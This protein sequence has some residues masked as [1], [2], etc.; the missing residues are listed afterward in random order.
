MKLRRRR[1]RTREEY[2]RGLP[3]HHEP[4][5][6]LAGAPP[7][8]SALSFRIVLAGIALLLSVAGSVAFAIADAPWVSVV[9]G[10]V[11]VCSAINLGWVVH[12]KRR[13]EPG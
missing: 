9:L 10:A 5:G 11:A 6:G 7:T 3:D 2:E 4:T 1:T 8:Y 13:G 12:R